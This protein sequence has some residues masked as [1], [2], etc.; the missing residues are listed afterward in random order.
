MLRNLLIGLSVLVASASLGQATEDPTP[1]C[2]VAL[3]QDGRLKAIQ[4]KI[5][6]VDA[7]YQT[8]DM[9]SNDKK[10]T[11]NERSLIS[12]WATEGNKCIELGAQW[13]L[14]NYPPTVVALFNGYVSDL[15]SLGADLY[16]GKI[17]YGAFAKKRAEKAKEFDTNAGKAVQ[18]YIVQQQAL[19]QQQRIADQQLKQREEETARQNELAQRQE[20]YRKQEMERQAAEAQRR[21]KIEILKYLNEAYKPIPLPKLSSTPLQSTPVP[22]HQ[23]IRQPSTTSCQ[24]IG[25]Q[26]VC[27]S[28]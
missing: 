21:E 12:L 1:A 19:D 7:K 25:N 14:Q 17:T 22:M 8:L 24:W 3:S 16:S 23:P 6:I 10:P 11:K 2:L 4:D 20:Y 15:N 13:R 27:N 5:A 18:E 9:L 26:F 28:Y